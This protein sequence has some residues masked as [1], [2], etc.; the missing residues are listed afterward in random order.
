MS[1]E[2]IA[3]NIAR[4][5][6]RHGIPVF[7]AKPALDAAGE[8]I[9]D[10]GHSGSGYWFPTG[11]ETTTADPASIDAW[12]SGDALGAV[13]GHGIDGVDVDPRNGGDETAQQWTSAG[14]WPISLGRQ[15]TPSG[16]WH[17]IVNRLG[18][19]SLDHA[20]PGVDVKAGSEHP[21]KDGKHGRGFLFIAPTVKL[22]KSTGEIGQY[23]W[24]VEPMLD[25]LDPLDDSGAAL[26]EVIATTKEHH[27]EQ[28]DVPHDAWD[29]LDPDKR[30]S[31]QNYLT[32]TIKGIEAEL[33]EVATW[34]EKYRDQPT[35][36]GK[37]RGWQKALADPCNRV[38][39]LA[40]ADWTPWTMPEAEGLLRAV[41]P[42]EIDKAVGF[43]QTWI[44]Q[45]NRRSAAPW[46]V[47]LDAEDKYLNSLET[48][49]LVPPA[50][51]TLDEA[52]TVFRKW[53]GDEYDLDVLDAVL[54]T[55]AVNQLSGD[56]AWLLVVSGSGA[57]KTETVAP[58]EA[59]G[60][61]VTSTISSEGA[62]LSGTSRRERTKEA[63]GGFLRKIGSSG[64]LVI[65]DVTSILSMD[66]NARGTVLAA[67]REIYDGHWER[68]LG[69]DGGQSL[70]WRGRLVVIGAVT[71]AWDRAHDVIASMGDRFVL[72]RLDSNNGR[73][74]S[75]RKA[76][77]NTGQEILMRQELGDAVAGVLAGINRDADLT[78]TQNEEDMILSLADIV[79]LG[80]TGV[81]HD[82]RGDVIDAHAPEMPTRFAKQLTQIMRGGLTLGIERDQILRIVVRCA[83]DSMPPLRLAALLDLRKHPGSTTTEVRKRMGK[84]RATV[85][86]TLQALQMLGLLRC[87]EEE[88]SNGL[89]ITWRYSLASQIDPGALEVLELS[90]KCGH[91]DTPTSNFSLYKSNGV[92]NKSGTTHQNENQSPSSQCQ[93]CQA[94][95]LL[96][97]G[98]TTCERCRLDSEAKAS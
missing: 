95:L 85:D 44:A 50:P 42:P 90:Q 32:A 88:S 77:S 6:T 51:V 66:R 93:T 16:G 83:A 63:T 28:I 71:T 46:P 80:R 30:R 86:R 79:T 96:D 49:K 78:L 24:T 98:R 74:A 89:R 67:L 81:D 29:A 73:T 56:P 18:V 10:G 38:G 14:M 47:M 1:A 60:A 19:R 39:R 62:L 58:L 17:D 91:I 33:A 12:K 34:P 8:W 70:E 9:P 87:D 92:S 35:P 15:A 25:E 69:S 2:T 64:I 3:L 43:D 20:L 53:L 21:D 13:M 36:N 4:N 48:F 41:I 59:A 26:A 94:Q 40:R 55:A 22:S 52:H 75:G 65:K 11:W 23:K 57:A 97:N 68:N 7:V 82:Y 27:T 31:V 72:I 54:A 84:P 5:L 37:G 76:I 45:R 61:F